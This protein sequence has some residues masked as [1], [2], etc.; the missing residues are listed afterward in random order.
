M[1]FSR[2]AGL[3]VGSGLAVAAGTAAAHPHVWIDMRTAAQL[4]PQ[5]RVAAVRIEWLF[6]RFYSAYAR[7]DVDADRDGRVT[8]AEADRWAVTALGNIAKVGYF[9]ELLVD[10]QGLEPAGADRPVGRWRDDRLFMSFVVRLATPADPRKVAVGYL[11]YDPGFYIDIRH[12]DAAD[13]ATV[14]GPGNEACTTEVRRSD[15]PPEVVASAA[16][17]DKD[18][19]APSGLGRL[20]ADHVKVTCR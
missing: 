17:L 8:D 13:A 19:T 5:G 14:E 10:G 2:F 4:D 3:L 16:A 1:G 18:A 7:E 20:F 15:P 6:D 9:A 11:S 12:P